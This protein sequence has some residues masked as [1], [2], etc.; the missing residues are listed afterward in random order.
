[1]ARRLFP[2][3]GGM[4]II[5]LATATV[6]LFHDSDRISP[7]PPVGSNAEKG[8]VGRRTPEEQ[9]SIG[10]AAAPVRTAVSETAPEN[11]SSHSPDTTVQSDPGPDTQSTWERQIAHQCGLANED[12][13]RLRADPR[14]AAEVETVYR[15]LSRQVGEAASKQGDALAELVA[16]RE[17]AGRYEVYGPKDRLPEADPRSG[18]FI[19]TTYEANP[20]GG[21]SAV[22]VI[23]IFPGEDVR[24]DAARRETMLAASN[25]RS[26]IRALVLGN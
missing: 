1:V 10:Q 24:F 16:R 26:V 23:R 17:T 9:R 21:P 19:T 12:L 4:V 25:R 20:G 13:A 22:R 14:L 3:I 11:S 2:L 15:D 8:P 5:G 6:L 18:E 7:A